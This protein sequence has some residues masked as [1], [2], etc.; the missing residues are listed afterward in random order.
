MSDNPYEIL[1]VRKDATSKEIKAAYRKLA[2]SLHPDLNPGDAPAEPRYKAVSAAYGLLGDAEKRARFDRG[3]ID[4]S[5]A[6]TPQNSFYRQ[7]AGDG[8]QHQYYS[9]QGFSD[10]GDE[11]DFFSELFG[12]ARQGGRTR[13]GAAFKGADLRYRLT[14]D[15]TDAALGAKRRVT[16]PDGVVLDIT[17]PAGI[18]DGQTLRL[19]GKGMPGHGGGPAGD[20]YVTVEVAPHRLFKRQ[21]KDI[22][23]DLP[24]TLDE[25]VLGGKVTVPTLHGKLS[26]PVPAGS[27]NGRVLRLKGKGIKGAKDAE[28]GHQFVTLRVILPD[29]VDDELKEFM[30][31]WRE[32]HQYDVR[33]DLEA[34]A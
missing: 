32:K 31:R 28:A 3:E 1:G 8:A 22:L 7:Y 16:M 15:F 20:A 6:E 24:I 10:L 23:M 4:A 30:T 9:N 18:A 34:G 26:V 19:K 33:Q 14:V 17:V 12:R 25:A 21:G 27:G 2:K 11:S 13:G 5:G 29:E